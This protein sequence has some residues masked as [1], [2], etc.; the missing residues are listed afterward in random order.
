MNLSHRVQHET[1]HKYEEKS[2]YLQGQ[3]KNEK[4]DA[5]Y[6]SQDFHDNDSLMIWCDFFCYS[7]IREQH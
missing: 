7:T 2:E 6:D 1:E 5:S 4:Q 3:F